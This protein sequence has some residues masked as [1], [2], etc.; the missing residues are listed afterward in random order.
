MDNRSETEN[1]ESS[2]ELSVPQ[3]KGLS[4]A[5]K[6]ASTIFDIFEMFAICTAVIL[7]IFTYVARLTVVEGRSM[8]STLHAGNYMIVQSLGYT[9]HR[10]DIVV[11]QKISSQHYSNPIIKRVIGVGGDTIDIDFS[12]WT[13]YVNGEA[14]DEPYVNLEGYTFPS[15]VSFPLTVEEGKIFVMG[16]HRNYSSDSRIADIGQ[17]DERC[18]VGRAIFRILPINEMGY[19]ERAEYN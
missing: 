5:Q 10:G 6:I 17:I 18:V 13:V 19:M 12:T 3:N 16:D 9:P 4:V 11:I 8:E 2:N 1:T 14:I 7:L 15:E